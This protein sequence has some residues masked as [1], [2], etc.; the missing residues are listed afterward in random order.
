MAK[1]TAMLAKLKK[2]V[3]GEEKRG[4]RVRIGMATCGIS[5][6]ADK[7]FDAFNEAAKNAGLENVNII[8]TGCVGRCDLEPMAEVMRDNEA[9]VLY[10]RLNPEKVRRIVEEH[11][12]RGE[13]V[14]EYAV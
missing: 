1:P 14:A 7:V 3:R 11:L 9:P 4:I 8:S 6:G 2:G 10:I 5:A 12:V 13:I